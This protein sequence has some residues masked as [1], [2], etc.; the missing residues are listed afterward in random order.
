LPGHYLVEWGAAAAGSFVLVAVLGG[1]VVFA[2]QTPLNVA[3][4]WPLLSGPAVATGYLFGLSGQMESGSTLCSA[5][6]N[7]S[8]DTAWSF[9]AIVLAVA[10][11][12]IL[13]GVFAAASATKR[14]VTRLRLH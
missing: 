7:G 4:L 3:L 5:S 10:A 8:C 1:L 6:A 12:V 11:A 14:L 13:G 2:K 9:G